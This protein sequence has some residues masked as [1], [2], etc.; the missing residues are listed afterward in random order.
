MVISLIVFGFFGGAR[1]CVLMTR[2][3]VS[4]VAPAGFVSTRLTTPCLIPCR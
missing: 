1:A 2:V 3:P 4:R